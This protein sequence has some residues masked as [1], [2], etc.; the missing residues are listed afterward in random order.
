[1]STQ[2]IKNIIGCIISEMKID[3]HKLDVSAC[4]AFR[5]GPLAATWRCCWTRTRT[6][7]SSETRTLWISTATHRCSC[8]GSSTCSCL[9]TDPPK[10]KT[11]WKGKVPLVISLPRSTLFFWFVLVFVSMKAGSVFRDSAHSA[12]AGICC[13]ELCSYFHARLQSILS[14]AISTVCRQ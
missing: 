6:M 1:M 14:A 11:W 2:R 9:I 5:Y 4:V 10:S 12:L 13:L 3:V 7:R 8:R